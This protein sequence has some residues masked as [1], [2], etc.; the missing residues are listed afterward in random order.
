MVGTPNG[1]GRLVV[2]AQRQQVFVGE[3]LEACAG[4]A[5]PAVA[6]ELASVVGWLTRAGASVASGS[7]GQVAVG[8]Q[9]DGV[10]QRMGQRC[11]V[12][13]TGGLG[14]AVH[15]LGPSCFFELRQRAGVAFL[16]ANGSPATER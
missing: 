7:F 12:S 11:G 13:I 14:E 1:C 15:A 4:L 16:R 3:R 9:L 5:R 10:R 6:N 2:P 8:L